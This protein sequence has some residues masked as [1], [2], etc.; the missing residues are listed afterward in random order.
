VRREF[1][2]RLDE[3]DDNP[4][5]FLEITPEQAA[6]MVSGAEDGFSNIDNSAQVPVEPSNVR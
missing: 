2:I 4:P 1:Y 6:K 3:I 5:T